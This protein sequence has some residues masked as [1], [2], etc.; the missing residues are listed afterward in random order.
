MLKGFNRNDIFRRKRK[1]GIKLDEED[2]VS[3]PEDSEGEIDATGGADVEDDKKEDLTSKQRV[4]D[5]WAA[6]KQDTAAVR[7]ATSSGVKQDTGKKVDKKQEGQ[8]LT[9]SVVKKEETKV[10]KKVEVTEIF[11]FAGEEVKYVRNF[12][13]LE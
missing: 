4:D 5:L 8:D 2:E 11:D 9:S 13:A 7:P 3:G 10:S 6:F 1:G 12:T